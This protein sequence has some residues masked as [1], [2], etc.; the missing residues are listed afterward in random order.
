MVWFPPNELDHSGFGFRSLPMKTLTIHQLFRPTALFVLSLALVVWPGSTLAQGNAALLTTF[1]NPAPASS[2]DF[3]YSVAALGSDRVLVGA[4]GAGTA[5]LLNLN[6][7]L[8]TTF[9]D[10]TSSF[11]AFGSSVATV[12]NDR[13]LIGAYN[14]FSNTLQVG[15][16]FLFA[17]NGTTLTTFT[18]P[19]PTTVQAFGWSVAAM[20]SDR[21]LI[22][23]FPN[24]NNP[25][26]YLGSVYLFRTN[27]ALL[28]TFTNPTP[29]SDGD[30]GQIVA[31]LGNDRVLIGAYGA[32]TG[33]SR[34]GVA[35]LYNTNGALLTTFTNPTPAASDGFG[36]SV[37]GVGSDRV[38]IGAF[39]DSTGASHTGSAY[40]F[41]TNG[42]LLTT[43]TNP[44]PEDFDIFGSSVAGVGST[45]VLI[46]AY[47]DSAGTSQAG[48]AY[49][50]STNGTLL[51]TFTN[52]TPEAQDWFGY[53][54]SAVGVDQ[55]IVGAVWDNTGAPDAGSAYL[56][57][58][59][60]PPLS[61]A[62]NTSTV[63]VTWV[64]PETGLNLQQTDL[65]A[66]P[67]WSD[68]ANSVFVSGVTNVVQQ[69]IASGG[70]N[71][72]YRLHRP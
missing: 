10:P 59:P 12:G 31:A 30:F 51:N 48:S 63:S 50:F 8:L 61:I 22:S 6:G 69:S 66:P 35:Y 14:Y 37:A 39:Q 44:A 18:N 11:D 27:G 3:G 67:T 64:T 47:Q 24:V 56:Y 36:V 5:Y 52:P 43:F 33:A 65:L 45:R 57:A 41:N 53:S 15:R 32:N 40:L 29:S 62:Q 1:T 19:S 58:L 16:A 42:T 49:L 55:V 28:T 60:Y 54:A 71:R 17:T 70:T 2:A 4:A 7:T 72:F 26:P 21:V 46:A 34:A 20:G 9:T 38:I 23:G 68:T 13:I 25:P